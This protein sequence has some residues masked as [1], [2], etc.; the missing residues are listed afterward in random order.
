MAVPSAAA[1]SAYANTARLIDPSAGLVKGPGE[2]GS[3]PSFSSMLSQAVNSVIDAG[4][5]SDAQT[6]AAVTGKSDMVDVVTA[7]SESELAVQTMVAVRDK[8]IEAYQ[9][10]MSMPI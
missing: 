6:K 9:N 8:V 7:V 4:H 2:A 3:G 5:K 1:A 10:I